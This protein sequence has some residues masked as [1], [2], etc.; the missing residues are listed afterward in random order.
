MHMATE[1]AAQIRAAVEELR[2]PL[3]EHFDPPEYRLPWPGQSRALW[4]LADISGRLSSGEMFV[5][6]VD[7]RADPVRSVVKYWPLL[8][9]VATAEFDHPPICLVEVSAV[10]STYGQGFQLLAKFAGRQFHKLYPQ[11][12]R[13]GFVDLGNRDPVQLAP[14]IVTCFAPPDCATAS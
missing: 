9:A 2:S 14:A 10:C 3:I 8:H 12:F 13:F 4:P 6:E 1:L 11:R 7:D 5:I